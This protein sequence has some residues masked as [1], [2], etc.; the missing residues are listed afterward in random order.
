[1]A[2]AELLQ[3]MDWLLV[4]AVFI[5][6]AIG[7]ISLASLSVTSDFPYFT[8]Q[9]VWVL[10]GT[11]AFISVASFDYRIFRSYGGLLLLGYGVL[12]VLLIALLIFAREVRGVQSW[13]RL[14]SF[15][16]EPGEFMKIVLVLI[17]AKYFSKRHV[18][19]YRLR[20]LIIS[21]IYAAIPVILVLVQP[22]L[23]T[24]AILGM[25]WFGIVISAGIK[26]RHLLI[27]FLLAAVTAVGGWEFVLAPYQKDRVI[28]FLNPWSDPLGSGYNAIQSMI[29]VG[30][31]Q[32]L[33]KGLGY[34]SQTHL[35]FLP[36]PAT[37]FIFA[38]FAEE[39]GFLGILFFLSV[40]SLFFYRLFRIGIRA[41]DNFA[42]LVILGTATIFFVQL[43]IH[44]G[45][46]MGMLPITGIT[47]PLVS[48]GGSSMLTALILL[49]LCQSIAVR[50]W[51]SGAHKV[52][53][54]GFIQ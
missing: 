43:M 15:G 20:H 48:Y 4:A 53:A 27:F 54:G 51:K 28:S 11:A 45:M 12:V 9:L 47:L 3:R 31:G 21:G 35:N 19:I 41:S 37:D 13:F 30:S 6:V 14:G 25:I 29:A 24:A 46:N 18:E 26:P 16:I 38:A 40:Y 23:G 36:E 10:I 50:S 22:D 2:F 42:K 39:W 32:I 33:G 8:R 44:V 17:L 7:L 5:L 52:E 49:G 34:G 1:M